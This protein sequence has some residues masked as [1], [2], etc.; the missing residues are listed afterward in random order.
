MRIVHMISGLGA[1]GAQLMLHRLLQRSTDSNI[2]VCIKPGSNSRLFQSLGLPVYSL[3]PT[4]PTPQYSAIWREIKRFAPDTVVGWMYHGNLMA[5]LLGR[6]LSAKI[7]WNVRHS[8]DN[9][10]AEKLL[11]RNVIRMGAV[12]SRHPDAI[13]YNSAQACRQHEG[14][15]FDRDRSIVL[16]NGFEIS[17]NLQKAKNR[18]LILQEFGFPNDAVLIGHSARY[19]P[20]KNHAGMLVAFKNVVSAQPNARLV[21]I[22]QGVE[23]SNGNL[24]KLIAKLKLQNSVALAGERTDTATVMEAFNVLVSSSSFGEGFP[25]VIGEAM[26]S[27]TPVVATDVGDT[28]YLIGPCGIVIPPC[29][30]SELSRAILA[31]LGLSENQREEMGER[32]RE[33]IASNFLMDDIALQY[34]K[35]W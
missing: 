23:W 21:M 29:N 16:P 22:G 2:V 25:N 35:T 12:L 33:R 20:M 1:G 19:H 3:Y 30:S 13:V 11:T 34:F 27:A 7:V 5:T 31:V 17:A 8:L 14:L 32:A 15:G 9:L 26:A 10:S 4:V 18:L 28:A 6:S 24:A